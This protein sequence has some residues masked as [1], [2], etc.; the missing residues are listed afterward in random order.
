M[1]A[2]WSERVFAHAPG[3]ARLAMPSPALIVSASADCEVALHRVSAPPGAI[4]ALGHKRVHKGA[5]VGVVAEPLGDA[6]ATAGRAWTIGEDGHCCE[7][8][9]DL[10]GEDVPATIR[11]RSIL[12][13]PSPPSAV[14]YDAPS[15]ML[16]V[17]CGDRAVHLLDVRGSPPGSHV[18]VEAGLPVEAGD[19]AKIV[20]LAWTGCAAEAVTVDEAGLVVLWRLD[21]PPPGAAGSPAWTRLEALGLGV[22]LVTGQTTCLVVKGQLFVCCRE[23]MALLPAARCW[24]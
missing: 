3:A 14:A 16:A 11:C 6:A 22:R 5:I 15:G 4:Q 8:E 1:A 10:G 7:V 24:R 13:A 9:Y 20:A 19:G 21:G 18:A 12:H 2:I 23:R 17:L